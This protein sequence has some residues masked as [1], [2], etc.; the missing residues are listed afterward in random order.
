MNPASCGHAP[1]HGIQN[2]DRILGSL[3]QS[4]TSGVKWNFGSQAIQQAA[5]LVVIAVLARLLSPADFGLVGMAMVVIGFVSVFRDLGTSAAV[6]QSKELSEELVSSV[7]WANAAFGALG[8]LILVLAAPLAA[9]YYHEPRITSVLRVLAFSF[10]VSGVTILQKTLFERK[11]AFRLIAKVEMAGV[12][13]G[14]LAGISSA[15]AGAHVWALVIQSVTTATVTSLLLWHFSD[16]RPRLVFHWSEIRRIRG[17]SANLTGYNTFSYFTGNAD[18]LIIGHFLGATPLGIYTLAYRIMLYPVQSV[19]TV[20]SRVL[21]PMYS[22]LQDDNNHFRLAYLRT[23]ALLAF[24]TFPMMLGMAAVATPFVWSVFGPK[25]VPAIPLIRILAPIGML[26]SVGV[27]VGAIYLA[28][29]RTDVQLRW[30]LGSSSV[31]VLGF[32]LGLHWGILGITVSYAITKSFLAIPSFAIPFRY[33]ALRLPDF[34]AILV[35]PFTASLV[36]A[37]LV[38]TGARSLGGFSNVF[39]LQVLIALGAVSYVG[40]SWFINRDSIC[41][42]RSL[43]TT[44]APSLSHSSFEL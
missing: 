30:G 16:F 20:V 14:A 17:Y 38:V 4:A 19:T 44:T 27:T 35:R 34:V 37:I 18:Y 32:L 2:C 39:A 22:R 36:M 13:C 33:I 21:F 43:M 5:Q 40:L 23:A 6:I 26:Q 3:A 15:Q 8:T 7:F 25:W 11:L 41:Q 10:V 42:L 9:S 12:L 31:V 29:G 1:S 28:K 24:I